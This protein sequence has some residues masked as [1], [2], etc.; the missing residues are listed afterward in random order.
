MV[1]VATRRFKA[2]FLINIAACDTQRV[3]T[4][5][6]GQTNVAD[7]QHVNL[8]LIYLPL[9]HLFL[10]LDFSGAAWLSR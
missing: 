10:M 2:T 4:D 1:S 5:G 9:I 3:Q 7:F 6:D 8:F